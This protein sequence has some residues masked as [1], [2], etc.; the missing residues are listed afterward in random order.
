MFLMS[1]CKHNI[2]ANSGF[3]WWSAYLNKNPNKIVIAPKQFYNNNRLNS[4]DNTMEDWI[5]I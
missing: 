4:K 2:I 1:A 3:S 5:T